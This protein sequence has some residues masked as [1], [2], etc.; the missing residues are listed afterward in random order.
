MHINGNHWQ[1]VTINGK[2]CSLSYGCGL[3]WE[4]PDENRRRL[5]RWLEHHGFED[6]KVGVLPHSRQRNDYSCGWIML[7]THEADVFGDALWSN[8]NRFEYKV[9]K[10]LDMVEDHNQVSE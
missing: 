7:N 5:M 1:A 3:D 6:T 2:T 4:L 9:G 8:E 10:I